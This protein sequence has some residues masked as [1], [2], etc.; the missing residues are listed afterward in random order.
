VATDAGGCQGVA[1]TIVTINPNPIISISSSKANICA[2]ACVSFTVNSSTSVS[3]VSWFFENGSGVTTATTTQCFN[4]GG[5]YTSTATIIDN[6]G[7]I[8]GATHTIEVYPTPT[9]DFIFA[10]LRPIVDNEIT[11]TD[12]S[13][14]AN[15]TE[16]YWFFNS[17]VVNSTSQNPNY[18][19]S[20]IGPYAVTL[21]VKSDKGCMDTITQLIVVG[22]DYGIYVPNSFTPNGDG[23][24]DVF[25]AKGY[26]ISKF[27]MSIFDRWGEKMF[28]TNDIHNAWDGKYRGIL[29]KEDAYTWKIDLVNVFG[30]SKELTGHVTLIK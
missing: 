5:V 25:S 30:K 28:T 16:W 8:G 19:Y 26:G 10:P 3:N 6:N 4:K 13:F 7:C 12:A 18:I 1:T 20:E 23:L 29:C 21:I 9:A 15:I 27:E 11:F 14:G 22:E 24:N 17:Q 2:P